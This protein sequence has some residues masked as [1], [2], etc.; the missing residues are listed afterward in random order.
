MT[1]CH[2]KTPFGT[3]KTRMVWLSSGEKTFEDMFSR[4]EKIPACDG[5][6]DRQTS[7]DGIVRAIALR[8]N[9]LN[10]NTSIGINDSRDQMLSSS[11]SEQFAANFHRV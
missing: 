1:V 7:C 4:F 9:K 3:E 8:D 10:N 2:C 6:T 5:R 11:C